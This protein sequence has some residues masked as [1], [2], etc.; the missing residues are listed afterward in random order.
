MSKK[1]TAIQVRQEQEKGVLLEQLKKTP[2]VQIACEKV[3]TGRTTYYRW[4]KED[5]E[6]CKEADSALKEGKSLVN[7]MAESQLLTAIRD[8]NLTAIIFWLKNQHKDYMTRMEVTTK[9]AE[10]EQITPEQEQTIRKALSL[11]S[12]LPS[13]EDNA[14]KPDRAT[15]TSA[16]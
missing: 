16:H 3:G 2:I 11:A 15:G 8:G 10:N 5:E 14:Q 7:D 6:F 12:L 13:P 1:K 9:L 4:R